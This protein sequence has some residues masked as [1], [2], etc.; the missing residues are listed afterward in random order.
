MESLT[1][2]LLDDNFVQRFIKHSEAQPKKLALHI[3][4]MLESQCTGEEQVSYG[5]LAQQIKHYQ[6]LWHKKGWQTNDRIIVI[7]KPSTQLYAIAL[8]LLALGMTPVFIDTGMG[9]EK[10]KMAIE[11][12]N[13]RAIISM[14]ALLKWFWLIPPMWT[15]ERLAIDEK[16]FGF[17]SLAKQLL[18]IKSPAPLAAIQTV[19][20][21]V[22][23]HG[24]ISFTSG[25][26]GRPKGADRT[27]YSLIQQ[28]LAIRSHW[29]DNESDIDCPCFPV[30]VLH[31]LSCGMTTVM[32]KVDLAQPAQVDG[33]QVIQQIEQYQI[34]R[35]SGAPAYIQGLVDYSI[36]HKK[37]NH[38]VT[39][40]VVGGATVSIE[41]A[42]GIL[43]AFP[44]A[45]SRIVYGSTEAEPIASIDIADYLTQFEQNTGCSNGYNKGY[46]VGQPAEQVELLIANVSAQTVT[47]Q[48]LLKQVVK[49]G[50]VGEIL[51]SGK[52]VL[53]Q[54]V[55]NPKANADNKIKR[56][57]NDKN[58]HFP[59]WHRTGD[60]GFL[61][62]TGQLWLTG[63]VKDT[64][65]FK[66][67]AIQPYPLEQAIDNLSGILRSALIHCNDALH[68]F[69]QTTEQSSQTL[70]DGLQN[71]IKSILAAA[72]IDDVQIAV[73]QTMPVD[74]RH[75]SKIDRLALRHVLQKSVKK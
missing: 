50:E 21:S 40:L 16:G 48:S 10:I 13:A 36:K 70:S 54:Y 65:V 17:Q 2:N 12:A 23:D 22:S 55:D 30:M 19:T 61:D 75:N 29:P 43:V 34:T 58:D 68:L 18:T 45:Y 11:D 57:A 31:N 62:G 73:I 28:H 72:G 24:L 7:I 27:H 47:E 25:S 26:T 5:E 67:G 66:G 59:V 49:I 3:S 33:A 74:G 53:K 71:E 14:K 51:V 64:L 9:R 69:V 6:A 4:H 52:H 56:A 20:R 46:L 37:T 39:T 41:L 1:A 8:S 32:P 35:I 42:K 44:N 63:R 15:L 38:S 60:T